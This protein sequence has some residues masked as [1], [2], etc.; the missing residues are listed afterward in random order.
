MEFPFIPNDYPPPVNLYLDMQQPDGRPALISTPGMELYCDF[1]DSSEI[2]G[3]HHVDG[4]GLFV[5]CGASVFKVTGRQAHELIDTLSTSTGWVWMVDNAIELLISHGGTGYVY[6]FIRTFTELGE[7]ST[8]EGSA[9]LDSSGQIWSWGR[10]QCGQLGINTVTDRSSPV[11]VVGSHSFVQIGYGQHH[12][13]AR[14]SNG[15]IWAWGNNPYGQLGNNT[16]TSYSSPIQV[17]GSHSFVDVAGGGTYISVARKASGA[18]WS[19]GL[20]TNGQLGDNTVTARSSPVAVVGSHSFTE[21]AAGGHFSIARKASGEVWTWGFSFYGQLGNNTTTSYSS[22]IQVVGSHSFVEISGGEDHCLARKANGQVWAWGRNDNGQL[23]DNSTTARS[24]PVLVVG[25]HSFVEIATGTN[26]GLARK[27][28]GSIWAWGDNTYGQLGDNTTTNKS[29]PVV[30]VRKFQPLSSIGPTTMG[31]LT[32][33]DGYIATNDVDSQ[34][35]Y[36]SG[37][38]DASNWPDLDYTSAEELTDDLVAV[39]MCQGELWALGKTSIE[40]YL[41]SGSLDFPFTRIPGAFLDIGC[42][43]A[44]SVAQKD[45]SIFWV[46]NFHRIRRAGGPLAYS[47]TVIS[48][49]AMDEE[50]AGYKISDSEGFTFSQGGHDFYVITFPSIPKTWVYDI[51][52]TAHSKNHVWH[53]RETALINRWRARCHAEY[54]GKQLVGDYA[55]GKIYELKDSCLNDYGDTITRKHQATPIAKDHKRI[56]FHSFEAELEAVKGIFSDIESGSNGAI[57]LRA[58]GEAWVWGEN[59]TYGQLGDGT[60]TDKSSPVQVIGSHDFI[61]I[62]MGEHHSVG[63][64]S[65]GAAWSWGRATSGQLGDNTATSKSSP[66]AVVGSHSFID[67]VT[68]DDFSL[69]LKADGTAWSWGEGSAGELGDNSATDKSSPVIVVGSHSFSSISAGAG[70][71]GGIKM[72]DGSAWLWGVGTNGRLGDNS[73]TTKS[74]PVAVVG[75]HS[76]MEI[77]AGGDFSMALK[78]TGAA[79]AWGEAGK[80]QLGDNSATDKSSPVIVVGSHAFTQ[81]AAGTD[82]ALGLKSNGEVW[83]WGEG[84]LGQLGDNT[85][86]DKSSPV[87]VVGSHSFTKITAGQYHAMARK[88]NGEVWAWGLNTSGQLGDNTVIAKSSP[89]QV[90]MSYGAQTVLDWKDENGQWSSEHSLDIPTSDNSYIR[91][92]IRRLGTARSR[93]Y[94]LTTTDPVDVTIKAAYGNMEAEGVKKKK[95]PTEDFT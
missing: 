23:G 63:I 4:V 95:I 59:S 67:V 1:S 25:S 13:L 14:K 7:L 70:H 41:N 58:N 40:V 29:S 17:V 38:Y 33:I 31:T 44:A 36:I 94:R 54:D 62:D 93:A 76:F 46:D 60:V 80:G 77:S 16:T 75:S 15:D 73:A 89:V 87:A 50:L 81:I 90:V 49:P 74:S 78:S 35:W 3:M 28:N 71:A 57:A 8:T 43:A 56:R 27:A 61:K 51:T 86:T 52:S 53:Q 72:S 12:C 39:I 22:P 69:G 9:M 65:T 82:F 48:T 32:F 34:R 64:K 68:G 26:H 79:W 92:I 19:W 18:V 42:G 91:S 20:N 24:S 55:N 30:I 6:D 21:I 37:L 10:N 83:S 47:S 11:Q 88:A 2:R 5:V 85:K 84:S 66:V 45:M